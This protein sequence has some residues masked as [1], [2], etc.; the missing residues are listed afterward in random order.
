MPVTSNRVHRI[1]YIPIIHLII[2]AFEKIYFK[3]VIGRF[4]GCAV[5]RP[6]NLDGVYCILIQDTSV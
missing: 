4:C 2:E 3:P 1:V 5:S 6:A